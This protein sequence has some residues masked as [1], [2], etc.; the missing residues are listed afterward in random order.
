MISVNSYDIDGVIFMDGQVE[1]LRPGVNDIIIT[2]RSYQQKDETLNMLRGRGI[3][4]FVYFNPLSRT[5]PAYCKVVSGQHKARVI[6]TLYEIGVS[7]MIH[8]E[9]D[10][11]QAKEIRKVLPA[12]SRVVMIGD[13]EFVEKD[14]E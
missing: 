12:K 7:V 3:N 4:N 11:I 5:D 10:P 9:D 13:G 14:K 1:G 2:G 8:F 6:R